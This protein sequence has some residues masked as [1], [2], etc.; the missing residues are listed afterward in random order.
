[1]DFIVI[2]IIVLILFL[3]IRSIVKT[4]QNGGGCHGCASSKSCPSAIKKNC[5]SNKQD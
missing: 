2:A 3:A 5:S 1:M 4:K